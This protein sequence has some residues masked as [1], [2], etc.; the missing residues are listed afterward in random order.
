MY[1]NLGNN[2]IIGLNFRFEQTDQGKNER[3]ENTWVK[4]AIKVFKE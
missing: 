3:F 4:Y 2:F 1:F